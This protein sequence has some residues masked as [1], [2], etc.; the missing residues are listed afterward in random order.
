MKTNDSKPDRTTGSDGDA[1]TPN[2]EWHDC[3]TCG[4]SFRAQTLAH[5][6]CVPGGAT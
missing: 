6:C 4:A 2:H 1:Q 5:I 3:P